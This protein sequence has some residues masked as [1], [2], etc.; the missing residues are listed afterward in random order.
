MVYWVEE[1]H[2]WMNKWNVSHDSTLSNSERI[3]LLFHNRAGRKSEPIATLPPFGPI[4]GQKWFDQISSQWESQK[5]RFALIYFG[6]IQFL[7]PFIWNLPFMS[8]GLWGRRCRKRYLKMVEQDQRSLMNP[9]SWQF[10]KEELNLTTKPVNRPSYGRR[11]H[12][13]RPTRCNVWFGTSPPSW[14]PWEAKQGL[15]SDQHRRVN[16]S[17]FGKNKNTEEQEK[18]TMMIH[19]E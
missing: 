5:N 6:K 15:L 9:S 4:E 3:L 11:T 2:N 14:R 12:L 1:T 8:H 19:C 17:V 16:I 18:P 7:P 13:T 10:G